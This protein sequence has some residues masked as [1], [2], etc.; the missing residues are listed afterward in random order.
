[1]TESMFCLIKSQCFLFRR[2][3]R[4]A[5]AAGG[6]AHTANWPARGDTTDQHHLHRTA[7]TTLVSWLAE[8]GIGIRPS[9][10]SSSQVICIPLLH[11]EFRRLHSKFSRLHSEFTNHIRSF[12]NRIQFVESKVNRKRLNSICKYRCLSFNM[13]DSFC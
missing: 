1:M 5:G 3:W 10:G 8:I 2:R 9:R 13:L 12:E 4:G 7:Q 11:S 6:G